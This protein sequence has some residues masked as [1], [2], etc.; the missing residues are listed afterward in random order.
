M[1]GS[2]ANEVLIVIG[3]YRYWRQRAK[4]FP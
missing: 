2:K 3:I 1:E 4:K